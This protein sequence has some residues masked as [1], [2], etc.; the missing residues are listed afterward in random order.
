[1]RGGCVFK[2]HLYGGVSVASWMLQPAMQ[3]AVALADLIGAHKMSG[4][5]ARLLVMS[6]LPVKP[7]AVR[8][9]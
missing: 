3:R 4:I 9:C 8:R 7:F 2:L 1:M 6:F 5:M